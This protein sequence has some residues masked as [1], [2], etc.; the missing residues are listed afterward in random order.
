[1]PHTFILRQNSNLDLGYSQYPCV[2]DF[3]DSTVKGSASITISKLDKSAGI[4]SGT[5]SAVFIKEGCDTISIT[6][7]RFDIKY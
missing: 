7:G 2:Y 6:D 4:V 5:F 3:A 1:M